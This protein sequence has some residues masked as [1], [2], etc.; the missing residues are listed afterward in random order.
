V[1][2][3]PESVQALLLQLTAAFLASIAPPPAQ[4]LPPQRLEVK[5]VKAYVM[6]GPTAGAWEQRI[7]R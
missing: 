1:G 4:G 6:D 3:P 5:G 7:R 2:A